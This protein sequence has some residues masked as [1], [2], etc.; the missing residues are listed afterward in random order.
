MV[1]TKSWLDG[2]P[3]RNQPISTGDLSLDALD[4]NL[5]IRSPLEKVET[6]SVQ[7]VRVGIVA[8]NGAN[9]LDFIGPIDTVN[10]EATTLLRCWKATLPPVW[11]SKKPLFETRYARLTL[12]L[13]RK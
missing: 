1:L 13:I 2:C 4:E 11:Q 9:S 8:L 7:I 12:V 3:I 10:G 6:K 5:Y